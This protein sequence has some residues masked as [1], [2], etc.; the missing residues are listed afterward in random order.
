MFHLVLK[1]L[2]FAHIGAPRPPFDDLIRRLVSLQ[3]YEQTLQKHP[4]IVSVD[5]PSGWHVEEGDH[6][7]GGI[8]PDM[9]VRL[10]R[11]ACVT[12]FFLWTHL[13]QS[14]IKQTTL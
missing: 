1:V 10:S 14:Y 8:K 11:N 4:V 13:L 12:L 6:E 9:L 5:I 3:N 7:D 2:F